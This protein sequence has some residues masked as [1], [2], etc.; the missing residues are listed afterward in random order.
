M[1]SKLTPLS[2]KL[3]KRLEELWN[4]KEFVIGTMS[5]ARTE[6]ERATLLD[7]IEHGE[8]VNVETVSTFSLLLEK[9]RNQ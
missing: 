6:E 1:M 4:D 2:L 5:S 8:N 9:E 3:V 7:F